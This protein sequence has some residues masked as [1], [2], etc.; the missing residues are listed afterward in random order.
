MFLKAFS[1]HFDTDKKRG[2]F[3]VLFLAKSVL[4]I[5]QILVQIFQDK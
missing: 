4:S 3:I 5:R 2:Q 1:Q